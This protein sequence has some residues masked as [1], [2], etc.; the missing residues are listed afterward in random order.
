MSRS[1]PPPAD[2]DVAVD[3]IFAA[4]AAEQL[5]RLRGQRSR[6]LLAD[7]KDHQVNFQ[8]HYTTTMIKAAEQEIKNYAARD[9]DDETALAC[10]GVSDR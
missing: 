6:L 7:G 3:A 4:D 2:T 5:P 8:L 1:K 10:A 9:K